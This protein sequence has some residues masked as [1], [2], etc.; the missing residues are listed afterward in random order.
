MAQL[1][2]FILFCL[3]LLLMFNKAKGNRNTRGFAPCSLRSPAKISGRNVEW[4]GNTL[5]SDSRT[6]C[7]L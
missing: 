7:H 2:N 3:F 6:L 4:T 1:Y 5:H